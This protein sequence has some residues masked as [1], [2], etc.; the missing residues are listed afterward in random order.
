MVREHS[1]SHRPNDARPGTPILATKLYAP[2]ARSGLV[3]RPRLL[4]RLDRGLDSRL[5]LVSAPAGYGKT[6]L[7]SAW[8]A[9]KRCT[10]AWLSLDA[11]DNDPARFLRY[12]IATVQTIAHEVGETAQALLRSPQLPPQEAV[13]S[14]LINDLCSLPGHIVIVL[15]DYYLVDV[16]DVHQA[17]A[18]LLD[19][20]PAQIHLLIATRT[21]PPLPLARW[22]SRGEL[23]EVRA[24]HLRF[25]PDEATE[26]LNEVMGLGLSADDIAAIGARTE[27]WAAGLRLAALSM[28]DRDDVHGFVSAFT[29]SHHYIVDYLAEEVLSRQPD[30]V[31]AFLMQT[32]ILERMTGTLCNALTERRDGQAMLE[33]LEQ[34]NLFLIALDDERRWFRYHRLFSD[35]LRSRLKRTWPAEIA[36][37][38]RK[39]SEWF[40]HQELV[41]EAIAHAFA[42]QDVERA[43]MLVEQTALEMLRR[44]ELIELLRS[45]RALPEDLVHRRPWLCVFLAW[46]KYHYGPRDETDRYVELAEQALEAAAWLGEMERSHIASHIAAIRAFKA[47]QDQDVPRIF[48]MAQKALA[49]A[50]EWDYVSRLSA[51]AL[52]FAYWGRGDVLGAQ[53]AM[54]QSTLIAL[55]LDDLGHAIS[56]AGYEALQQIKQAR[57]HEAAHTLHAALSLAARPNGQSPSIAVFAYI[58]L[59]DLARE[60]DDLEAA[61]RYLTEA[62]E[63]CSRR[64]SPDFVVDACVALA[65]LRLAQ[66]E[67]PAA[68]ETLAMAEQAALRTQ[69][70]PFVNTWLDEGRIRLWLAEGNTAAARNWA[71][72]S[73]LR[74]DDPLS[75]LRDLDHINLARVWVAQGMHEPRAV[76]L[77][78]ALSLLERLRAAAESAGWIHETIKILV[79]QALALQ[80]IDKGESALDALS[81]ALALAE[82]AGYV[83]IF[84][85]EGLPMEK[86][87]RHAASRGITPRYVTRLLSAFGGGPETSSV[88]VQPLSEPLSER[89][90][91]VLRL[92]AT[93]RSNREIAEEL[94][95]ATGTVKKHLSNIF[96]KLSVRS[97]TQCVAR[98]RELN[99]L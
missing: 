50:P 5:I 49:L 32:S 53:R 81:S 38:H 72:Q 84:I 31:R 57:L 41:D 64:G 97:R 94:V 77:S 61:D 37:L 45:L 7:V 93:G 63:M 30:P 88:A 29:G 82:P 16:P 40:E 19:H 67:L 35:V 95:L 39:A 70:D 75:Y 68:R 98:A 17:V 96:G 52:S 86:L 76:D 65:C 62:V 56:G 13:L 79:L 71:E 59:G 9:E 14:P 33:Q 34:A 78:E 26:F 20:M 69:L 51:V 4:Q 89:E 85:D 23:V 91:Q 21:D 87:L 92:L 55:E 42:G 3:A 74:S 43:A 46:G 58:R 11:G 80:T 28:Q 8:L 36:V 90:L 54:R 1:A 25:T 15:D 48:E 27:G 2:P 44:G 10:S 83:R 18:F 47:I 6:T 22:R 12:L 99:L 24:A 73:E 66:N 60:W